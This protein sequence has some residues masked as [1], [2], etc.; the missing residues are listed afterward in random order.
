MDRK[1]TLDHRGMNDALNK[2]AALMDHKQQEAWEIIQ[3]MQALTVLVDYYTELEETHK[4]AIRNNAL[5]HLFK[6]DSIL[7]INEKEFSELLKLFREATKFILERELVLQKY[8]KSLD[9]KNLLEN[10]PIFQKLA[11]MNQ[12]IKIVESEKAQLVTRNKQLEKGLDELQELQKHVTELKYKVKEKDLEISRLTMELGQHKVQVHS[13]EHVVQSQKTDIQSLELN[14]SQMNR[15]IEFYHIP[16]LQ[17]FDTKKLFQ[18]NKILNILCDRKNCD[19]LMSFLIPSE[20]QQ[21]SSSC[22]LARGYICCHPALFK[23]VSQNALYERLNLNTTL[24]NEQ[25]RRVKDE[26]TQ[27]DISIITG[28]KRYLYYDYN[29][30]DL[31]EGLLQETLG[32]LEKLKNDL[33]VNKPDAERGTVKSFFKQALNI[34]EEK[35]ATTFKLSKIKRIP[36]ELQEKVAAMISNTPFE[37]MTLLDTSNRKIDISNSKDYRVAQNKMFRE[38]VDK[39][40]A[41]FISEFNNLI[42]TMGKMS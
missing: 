17:V 37:K 39:K 28:I 9:A 11:G 10:D 32:G 19:R 41:E 13:F 15:T 12:R 14:L 27:N 1:K 38:E 25:I 26:I 16:K 42:I 6:P 36:M 34:K 18:N 29:I 23:H 35:S 5:E 7:Q 33:S 30:L 22:K 4:N 24:L 31:M 40:S 20:L 21:L 2:K 3:K 8:Q